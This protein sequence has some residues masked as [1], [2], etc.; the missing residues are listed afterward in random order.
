MPNMRMVVSSKWA[1]P[2]AT[3]SFS[4]CFMKGSRTRAAALRPFIIVEGQNE[5]LS[6]LSSCSASLRSVTPSA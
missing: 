2:L 5:A 3:I 6:R 1:H 4:R